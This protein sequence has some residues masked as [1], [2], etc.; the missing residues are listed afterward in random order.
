MRKLI[1]AAAAMALAGGAAFADAHLTIS[2]SAEFA[3]DYDSESTG[4][5]HTFNHDFNV[6]FT[7]SG[8]TDGGL[9]FGASG[10]LDNES[11][12]GSNLS[13]GTVFISG[14][15][16]K[17]TFGDNGSAD[18]LS[19][20]I[21]DVGLND[22]GVD[23]VAEDI[24]GTTANEFR[25]DNSFGN[26]AFALSAGTKKA[27]KGAANEHIDGDD[28]DTDLGNVLDPEKLKGGALEVKKNQY[29]IGISFNASG[30][31]VGLGYDSNK[32]VSIGL[33]Y[34]TG[35]FTANAFWAKH[36]QEYKHYGSDGTMTA[37]ANSTGNNAH[38]ADGSFE[39][40]YTGIGFDLSY[41][42]GASTVTIA[43]AQADVDNIQPAWVDGS[44]NVS[45]QDGAK[46][47]FADA[48]F[49]SLGVGFSHDL[50]GG[51]KIV[52]GFAQV[53]QKAVGDLV[54]SDIGQVFGALSG[55]TPDDDTPQRNIA[56]LEEDKN[57][58]SIGLT[59]SF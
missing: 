4:S 51:A 30:A 2:G 41:A 47:Q 25:Y 22:V 58:A 44:G 37:A 29:A 45:T 52:A 50:G 36:D 24:Y 18:K 10:G 55:T 9:A 8:T 26:F 13:E 3:I 20:G 7:G 35:P 27:E 31:T 23:D 34:S 54:F 28:G 17:F 48:T 14:A 57:V 59:F 42:M 39:A 12:D 6:T 40:G 1:T 38:K 19:G 56:T 43:F 21:A 32:A 5:K 49:K 46:V 53:P 16:G 15:F 33:K 11:G